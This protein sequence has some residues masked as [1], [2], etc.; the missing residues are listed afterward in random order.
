[1]SERLTNILG[2][3]TLFAVLAAIW[4]LFGED[5]TLDQGARGEHTFAALDKHINDATE[6]DLKA[7][8]KTAVIKHGKGGWVV[9]E[10][11][12]YPADM[13]KLVGVLRGMALS[14]RR[15]PKTGNKDHFDRIGLGGKALAITLKGKD[16]K[17]LA[18]FDM[19]T[20]KDGADGRSLTYIYQEKDTRA[21]LVTGLAEAKA[22]PVWWLD[23]RV[24]DLDE[25]RFA[26]LKIG[27]AT[28]TRP[29]GSE[30]FTLEGLKKG[31]EAA[32]V[33]E[34]R[35]PSRALAYL[36]VT[37]VRKVANPLMDPKG[38]VVATTHDGLTLTLTL[39]SMDGGTWAQVA[40]SFDAKARE[41]GKA[42]ELKGA[43][44]DG[45]KEA[46]DID[47]RTRGWLYRLSD[48]TGELFTRTRKDFLKAK[49][50]AAKSGS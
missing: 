41:D 39:Y 20:R 1:M 19:G 47:A 48:R 31:E 36:S 11:D 15:D 5:P 14:K 30:D 49:T 43:P 46:A 25:S 34:L 18:Q 32:P 42:G 44:V 21:W 8:D 26:Q 35:E 50:D 9:I 3:L 22:D 23:T 29:L 28:L 45:A 24:L 4:V 37:D 6:L 10:R 7:G 33:W 27:D 2:Y 38:K 13:S 17:T 16:G 12:D 40:A